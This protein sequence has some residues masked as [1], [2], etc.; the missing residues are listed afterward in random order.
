MPLI[1]RDKDKYYIC[2]YKIDGLIFMLG[3]KNVKMTNTNV[4]SIEKIDDFDFNMRSILKVSLH[5]DIR[6]KLWIIKNKSKITAKFALDIIGVDTEDEED[7]IDP[8]SVFNSQFAVYLNDED[9]A[10]DADSMADGIEFQEG[11]DFQ[12]NDTEE[13]GYFSSENSLDVYLFDKNQIASSNKPVNLVFTKANMN[14]MV[15]YILT[16]T[17]HKKV[18]M[19]PLENTKIY[20]ELLIPSDKAYRGL[21]YLDQYYG[22]YKR[23]AV[24]FYDTDI[25]YIINPNGK[26]TAWKKKEWKETTFLITSHRDS[27]PGNGMVR[28]QKQKKYYVNLPEDNVSP[29]ST[30]TSKNDNYG[31][32]AKVIFTDSTRIDNANADQSYMGNRNEDIIY[33]RKDDNQFMASMAKARMEENESILRINGDNWD[34]RAFTPNKQYRVVFQDTRKQKKYGKYLYRISYAYHF[35]KAEDG[36]MMSSSHQIILKRCGKN[37]KTSSSN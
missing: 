22:F 1:D 28:K 14:Q 29:Q 18:L 26:C 31:S 15:G 16:S 11:D 17:K 2:Q 32:C 9:D 21:I 36:E 3:S 24:I 10:V 7:I 30:S 35:L 37:T 6:K 33:I 8:E 5:I 12:E 25:L 27:T 34:I 19:S 4:L 23:G 13:D 20:K